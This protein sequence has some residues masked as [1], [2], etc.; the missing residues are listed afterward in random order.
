MPDLIIFEGH[1]MTEF[2]V[3]IN[4]LK[5]A[6]MIWGPEDGI[7]TL[8]I[9]G[10][11]D[12]AASFATLAPLLPQCRLYALDLPGHGLSTH[13]PPAATYHFIDAVSWIMN[14]A[15]ALEL[16]NFALL[17]HSLG[18]GIA[19]IAAGAFPERI[20][21]LALLDAIGPI[22]KEAAESP[23]ILHK[24][25]TK[26]HKLANTP[27]YYASFA[28][29]CQARQDTGVSLAAATLLAKRGVKQT[30]QGY[31]WAHDRKLVLPTPLY[32]TQAQVLA[33]I[34]EIT[35][36]ICFIE[37]EH[38]FHFGEQIIHERCAAAQHLAQH[39]VPGGH[40]VHLEHPQRV[41]TILNKFF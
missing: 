17:G 6:G 23:Q 36:P 37:A 1:S 38:G 19:T 10:W 41:A 22:T 24:A 5:L 15:D 35:A 32:M 30:T 27:K 3:S 11:L 34:S 31:Y 4:S 33:M 14:L 8:A 21:Q 29:A 20:T 40:H 18:A 39:T 16:S 13:L 7:P 12:N 9:H 28:D 25:I 2:N 26:A